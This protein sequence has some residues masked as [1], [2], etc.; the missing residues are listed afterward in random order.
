MPSQ[1]ASPPLI[2]YTVIVLELIIFATLCLAKFRPFNLP[3]SSTRIMWLFVCY[4]L[5]VRG[6][7]WKDVGLRKPES[8]RRT[9]LYAGAAAALIVV[10][11]IWVILPA[12]TRLT[13]KTID[14]S[15]F[16]ALHGNLSLLVQELVPTWIFAGLAEE[17]IFRAGFMN[18]LTDLL[19]RTGM[20]WGIALTV[21]SVIFG[22]A[23][24]YQGITGMIT[25]GTIGLLLGILYLITG[26][27][28]WPP[29]ICHALVDTTFFTLVYFRLDATLFR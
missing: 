19:G 27:N 12:A 18:R 6:A 1:D 25:S 17:M 11:F 15:A 5:W 29:V 2:E 9:V 8:W 4:S 26:R 10:A 23:H 14:F 20:G 28:L 13:G 7:S 24:T 21:S 16:A 22:A 3:N